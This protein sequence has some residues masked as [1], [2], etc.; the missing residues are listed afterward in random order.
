MAAFSELFSIEKAAISIE[1]RCARFCLQGDGLSAT[2]HG[3]T[4]VTLFEIRMIFAV[5]DPRGSFLSASGRVSS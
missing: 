1:I 2:N 4:F 5:L 3:W